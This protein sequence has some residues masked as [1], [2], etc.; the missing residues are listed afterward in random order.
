MNDNGYVYVLMNPSLN[1]LVK[2]G[3]STRT[4][5]VRAQEL[6]TA[7][8]VPTPFT[9]VY[10][11]FFENC[12]NAEVFVHTFLENKGYR[13]SDNREFFE[14]S[15]K[16]AVDAVMEAKNHFGEFIKNEDN[17]IEIEIPTSEVLDSFL[18]SLDGLERTEKNGDPGK[19]MLM[20]GL[21]HYLGINGELQDYEE[22]L[23][24]FDKALKL[25]ESDAY[26]KIGIMYKFGLGV[27]ENESKAFKYF[28]EGAKNGSIDCYGEIARIME[29]QEH[30][31]NAKKSWKRY[32][33]L[34]KSIDYTYAGNYLMFIIDNKLDFNYKD[35]VV[36]FKDEILGSYKELRD[37]Q[38]EEWDYNY[39]DGYIKKIKKLLR[40]DK[41]KKEKKDER[42]EKI[43][44]G[45][46]SKP[47]KKSFWDLL[48]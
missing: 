15:I 34:S 41:K 42:D 35:K 12:S 47:S 45:E 38:E 18:D 33:E 31:E 19:I 39:Y 32:F 46:I 36:E 23:I 20:M 9:V 37:E 27:K 17:E 44:K 2:I 13:V 29:A 4:P 3:K 11:C 43:E 30:I 7:T 48:K 8:G 6:S 1:K 25:G 16:D 10:D 40:S 26:L 5:E 28:K 22:A 24:Y 14:V 21:N